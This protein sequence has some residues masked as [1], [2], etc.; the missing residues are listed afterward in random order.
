MTH[1]IHPSA[2][3]RT[4]AR[5]H[6]TAVIGPRVLIEED[7]FIGPY[8]IIGEPAEYRGKEHI[9]AG[10]VIKRGTRLTGLVTIDSGV[11]GP[12]IIGAGCYIMKHAHIGHDAKVCAGVTIS[13]GAKI[14]G[15]TI[16][17]Q[18]TNIGLN[19]VIHQKQHIAEGC[20]I[21]AQAMVTKKL[22]TEPYK[23][24]VGNPAK[25]LGNNDKHPNYIIFMEQMFNPNATQNND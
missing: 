5:I 12:T 18:H 24:Y 3:I 15:H 10:V 14:G 1:F 17:C 23:T 21:G 22:V 2:V 4:G 9:Q 13:C 20:M 8:C 6:P 25:L 7:V 19:A 16:V 11:D